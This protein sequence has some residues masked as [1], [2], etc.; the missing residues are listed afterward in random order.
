M[1][2]EFVAGGDE[3]RRAHL[4]V[5]GRGVTACHVEDGDDDTVYVPKGTPAE[6]YSIFECAA[7]AAFHC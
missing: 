4:V 5:S 2:P 6:N 7:I 3:F 1:L